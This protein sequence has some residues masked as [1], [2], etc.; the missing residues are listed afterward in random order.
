M[1]KGVR[2]FQSEG[3][4]VACVMGKKEKVRGRDEVSPFAEEQY[5]WLIDDY[6]R[7]T[8]SLPLS[9]DIKDIQFECIDTTSV[10][11]LKDRDYAALAVKLMLQRKFFTPK[12]P[13]SFHKVLAATLKN[14]PADS[15]ATLIDESFKR[16]RDVNLEIG[17]PS[18]E[19]VTEYY[20]NAKQIM[21]GQLLHGEI[22]KSEL[23][24]QLPC[25][26]LLKVLAPFILCRETLLFD[27]DR[28]LDRKNVQP[29]RI[30]HHE[31]G[32][33]FRLRNNSDISEKI[34]QSP[35]W[36][37][38]VGKDCNT[39]ELLAAMND[40]SEDDACVFLTCKI[41]LEVLRQDKIDKKLLD[42]LV[43]PSTRKDWGDYSEAKKFIKQCDRPGLSNKPSYSGR[44]ATVKI[45]QKVDEPMIVD[46]PQLVEAALIRLVRTKKGWKIHSIQG[47]AV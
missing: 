35:Y 47:Q 14:F 41:F 27:L 5:R 18:G 22:K 29:F 19:V 34:N 43:L 6:K 39:E 40:M 30:E 31:K 10:G 21:Y 3:Q 32:I 26:S 25:D 38:L 24:V 13:A 9:K 44:K 45:M 17:Y 37:N 7:I 46:T 16:M 1:E 42:S 28:V 2:C 12:E 23:A 4:G 8:A 33:V 11:E 20:E 36:S 15:D